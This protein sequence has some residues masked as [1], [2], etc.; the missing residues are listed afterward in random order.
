MDDPI[1]LIDGTSHLFRAY[2]AIPS[3]STS[4]GV[5]T[6]AVYGF[7]QMILK[8]LKEHRPARIAV[9]FDAPGPTFR[10]ALFPAYKANR[11]PAPPDL[12][13]QIPRVKEVTRALGLPILEIEGV[14]ADDVIGTLAIRAVAEGF[15]CVLVTGDKDFMQLVSDRITL[16]D[17]MKGATL[18]IDAV[19]KRFGVGPERVVDVLALAGDATDNIPGVKGVGEKTAA[20]LVAEHGGLEEIL[21]HPERIPQP[22]LRE[23]IAGGAAAARLSRQLAAIRTDVP[24]DRGPGDLRPSPP[25][26]SRLRALFAELEF[27]RLLKELPPARTLPADGYRLVTDRDA[28]TAMIRRLGEVP[29]FAI[30]TETTAKD[31]MR[32]A[33]V[34]LSFAA[35]PGEAWYVPVGHT[36]AP[37]PPPDGAGSP[38]SE[39][40]PDNPQGD[41]FAHAAAP[42]PVPAGRLPGQL[43]LGEVLDSIRPLLEADT[44]GKIGQNLKYDWIVLARHGVRLRGILGDTMLASYVLNPSKPSH[45]LEALAREYLGHHLISFE[46]VTGRGKEAISFD[47]VPIEQAKVYSCEDAD[48]AL[49]IHARLAPE[50]R[51]QDLWDLYAEVERPLLEILAGLEY[52]GVR[53]DRAALDALREEFGRRTAALAAEMQALA[54]EPFNPDSPK[55]LQH[56][57]FERLGLE[58]GRRIKT[59]FSTD[60]DV[61]ARL[62][63]VHPLPA[64]LLE[65]RTLAKL[66]STYAESLAGLIHP[67]TG[68]IHTSYN[69]TVTATGRLSSSEPNLQNIPVRTP[70]GRLIRRAFVPEPGWTFV[71]A[72]YSQIELRVLAH[73]SGD[74]SLREAF[75]RDEDIHART[76]AELFGGSPAE[77]GP[78]L[79]RRA[80]AVNFGILY[81]MSDHGL[82]LQLGIPHAEARSIIDRYFARYGAVKGYLDSVVAEAR[83]TGYVTTL[84]KRRRYLPD[85]AS[86][87]PGLRGFAERTAVNTPIQGSAADIIKLAMLRVARRLDRG[88]FRARLLL[89]VHDELV[90]EAPGDEADR[91][92][93]V[94]REEM[95]G[96]FPLEVPLKVDV[97]SGPNWAELHG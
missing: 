40:A 5:P 25:D 36:G 10:D 72:D 54:G 35:A 50:L 53:V 78:E 61:L 14:E 20:R 55:Q 74:P 58:P 45:G 87:Q 26:T 85:L 97:S 28:L 47:R 33:L 82:S 63:A 41:L 6:N 60:M 66:K 68:R 11:P 2:Y 79:R 23:R 12:V 89:Q 19:K 18:G 22:K 1:F 70:E 56:I 30:D 3:L 73:L 62:A 32:A 52:T 39:A 31:P 75:R 84:L 86:P 90:V 27:G 34:G 77:A 95:E 43:P 37:A 7:T 57:L 81:G 96:A 88:G 49:R 44:P 46:E 16:L 48:V 76:A 59:G 71:S 67:E 9:I 24:L 69:Q 65:Y 42:P 17:T 38:R 8:L 91:T 83:K 80:K 15:P 93:A 94:L 21:A 51:A 92:R 4:K 64:R 13:A 29:V